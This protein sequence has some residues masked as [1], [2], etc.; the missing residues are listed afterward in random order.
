LD[1]SDSISRLSGM[2][3]AAGDDLGDVFGVDLLL[4]HRTALLDRREVRSGLLDAA[5]DLGDAPVA[6][7][8]RGREVGLAL[9]LRAQPLQLLL[10]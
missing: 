8:G 10:Q 9:D 6:D 5:L 2:P 3:V 4:E 1:V 7:L